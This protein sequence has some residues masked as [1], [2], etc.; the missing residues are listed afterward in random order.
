MAYTMDDLYEEFNKNMR[1]A[2]CTPQEYRDN[3]HFKTLH[4]L[5]A[6]ALATLRAAQ[7]EEQKC[8]CVLLWIGKNQYKA[9]V[10]DTVR[11]GQFA[12]GSTCGSVVYSLETAT[13]FEVQ[14]CHG[15]VIPARSVYPSE[16]VLIPPFEKFKVTKVNGD[17]K[18][19]FS[20]QL[21]SIGTYSKYNCEWLTGGSVPR[22]PCHIGGLFLATIVLAMGTSIL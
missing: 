5:L 12:Q 2:G 7:K 20:M 11:F 6:D 9:N 1:V 16:E 3:F 17:G 19:T 14:T 13:M 4:F 18:S 22:A 21:E 8:R 10:G 15:V